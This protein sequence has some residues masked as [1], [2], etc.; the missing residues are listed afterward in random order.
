MVI[1]LL[2]CNL[3]IQLK[4]LSK[5]KRS[6]GFII[7][8]CSYDLILTFYVLNLMLCAAVYC[9]WNVILKVWRCS[10]L[11]CFCSVDF[12]LYLLS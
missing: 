1:V 5:S 3:V 10:H 6:D 2:V 12:I 11:I 9:L 4:Q 8:L 7:I